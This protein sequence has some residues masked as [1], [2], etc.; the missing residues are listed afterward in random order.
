MPPRAIR[1]RCLLAPVV[2]QD[3]VGQPRD[4]VIIVVLLAAVDPQG[5]LIRLV[6]RVVVVVGLLLVEVRSV[7]VVEAAAEHDLE[8]EHAEELQLQLVHLRVAHPAH[9]REEGVV[10]VA[11]PVSTSNTGLS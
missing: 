5:L 7:E 3:A 2:P 10:V 8:V 1:R 6:G 4:P 11:A 9:A